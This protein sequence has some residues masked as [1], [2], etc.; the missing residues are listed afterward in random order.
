MGN[1]YN[2]S[3]PLPFADMKAMVLFFM[4]VPCLQAQLLPQRLRCEHLE[5]PLG[6]DV[7][8][9]RL[10]WQLEA[11]SNERAQY[12]TA[13]R[14]LVASSP[15][16]LERNVGDL[17]DSGKV[18]SDQSILVPYEGKALHS[19]LSCWWK[20]KAWDKQGQPGP[21]ST[22]GFWE[23]A[24][25]KADDWAARWIASSDKEASPPPLEPAPLFRR[26]FDVTREIRQ[27]RAYITGLGYFEMSLNGR[28]VGDHELDPVKS[29]YDRRVYYL[30]FDI[31][32][33]LQE[34]ANALGVWLGTGWFNMHTKAVW[35]FGQAPWRARP[36]LLCQLEIEYVDGSRQRI[37]SD[38]SWM[39]GTGPII[40]DG[41]R[42]GETYD[43]RLEQPG[44]KKPGFD[45]TLWISAAEVEG[46][47][48]K[49]SAQMLPP[50]RTTRILEPHAITEV[51]PGV[52]VYDFNQNLAG[53]LQ[54]TVRAPAGTRISLKQGERLYPDG[55]V[56]QKQI[57]RFIRSGELQ[58]D[59]YICKG[60]GL[61]IWEPRFVYHGFQYVEVRG[62]S[63]RPST[64][65]LHAKVLN[66]DFESAGFFVCSKELFNKIQSCTRWAFIG[67][68]HGIPTDCPHREKIG[69]TG[70]AHL[71]G[72]TGL[73][74]YD[75]AASYT[76]WIRD[77]A[78]EQRDDGD[79]PGVVPTSGWGYQHG[80]KEAYRHLG[81]GPQWEGAY[82][83]L[84]WYVY[85]Y[86]GDTRILSDHYAGF[87]RYLDHLTRH[88]EDGILRFGIDDHAP[89]RTKTP[90]EDFTTG[91][92]Y[93]IAWILSQSAR[94]LGKEADARHYAKMAESIRSAYN[95]YLYNPATGLY[96]SGSQTAQ[97]A[98]LYFDIVETSQRERVLAKLIENVESRDNHLDTG[99][100]GIKFLMN[101]LVAHGRADVAYRIASQ[102][103]FPSWGDWIRKGAN[104]LW[105]KW[106]DS[107]SRNHVMFGDISA[108]MFKHIGGLQPN[109]ALPGFKR[110]LIHPKF[111]TSFPDLTWAQVKH[112]SPYGPIHC[113]WR[114]DNDRIV[115]D[116]KVPVNS[117]AMVC[118]PVREDRITEGTQSLPNIQSIG[119]IQVQDKGICFDVGSGDYEF[120]IL[121]TPS[122]DQQRKDNEPVKIIFDTDMGSDCDDVGALA[123]LHAYAN[124]NRA[125]ILACVY[126]SGK[127]PYGAGIIEAINVYYGRPEIPV[128]A[129]QG[130]DIGDPVDKM[131]AETLAKD[132]TRFGNTIVHNR[133][134][135]DITRLNRRI[136][137]GQAG[138]RVT[139]VT[140]GHTRGLYDLLVSKPDDASS[141]DGV[142]LV[143]Q[144]VKRW[145]ALG[146]LSARNEKGH[147]GKD[148]NF[149][150]NG[151]APYTKYLVENFPKPM[152]FVTCGTHVLTGKSLKAT[153]AGNIVR[154]AYTE[155]LGWYNNKTLDDQRSSWDLIAVYYAVEGLG[156]YLYNEKDGHL[157]FD[158][159]KGC[160]W[161]KQAK[162]APQILILQKPGTNQAFSDYLNRMI[163]LP[164][165]R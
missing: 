50:I 145:V 60:E 91:F 41:I 22:V 127:V 35:G 39:V 151:T 116:L 38:R 146:A 79:L 32:K 53:K 55:T 24:L 120:E 66:T 136:L 101:G 14:I 153:P 159:E 77:F 12:Q 142:A 4:L 110:F 71:V 107:M 10:S 163:A 7:T 97:S 69:W 64:D 13:Y 15:E 75:M 95:K 112:Q 3:R 76:K 8:Q 121:Q 1:L 36:R 100:V 131:N 105:Q 6:I 152:V 56:E 113:T 86:T 114:R 117:R 103:T 118:L 96:A 150:F 137:A 119:N 149:F 104:T 115:L 40:F 148:W 125:K 98:P 27:A 28:K 44:W 144:K 124:Q 123:L 93:Q 54:L 155:W 134:A 92:Y 17:W 84:S 160:R 11:Q 138:N 78:D 81:Y 139:Y 154:T 129:Y 89:A 158:V 128:G 83:I 25:L 156:D 74:N 31:T 63:Q 109:P 65:L 34:G 80:K 26:E 82:V 132:T 59:T 135:E 164:P 42:N 58:T 102:T 130:D 62:L 30:T 70:D 157:D 16:K 88:A 99:V 85:I 141:L 126:S 37:I 9:P 46:P 67:N 140:V 23:V 143:Q 133:D 72:E 2:K 52:W 57:A 122:K 106:D 43:A 161:L 68:Y 45:D 87:R 61:E 29:R 51:K 147:Y 94:I 165:Q 18:S 21:W 47:K 49:L 33:Q 19:R 108:W 73:F 48:G 5:N 20:V 111:L 162:G 90:P